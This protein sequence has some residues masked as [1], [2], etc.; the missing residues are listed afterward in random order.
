MTQD[1]RTDGALALV[2]SAALVKSVSLA[3]ALEE[4]IVISCLI[5][6]KD[7][8]VEICEGEQCRRIRYV[9][10]EAFMH[11]RLEMETAS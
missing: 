11:R 7:I 6:H 8:N 1:A 4:A 9:G 5:S 2:G 3:S 10:E